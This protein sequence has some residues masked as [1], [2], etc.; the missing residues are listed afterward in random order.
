MNHEDFLRSPICFRQAPEGFSSGGGSLWNNPI[1]RRSFLK[2]TGGATVA[3]FIAWHSVSQISRA[4]TGA[5]AGSSGQHICR[6]FWKG[7][8][9][10]WVDFGQSTLLTQILSDLQRDLTEV[11]KSLEDMEK[12]KQALQTA[13]ANEIPLTGKINDIWNLIKDATGSELSSLASQVKN[14]LSDWVDQKV[15]P[16]ITTFVN[17]LKAS[18]FP[19][20]Y[21]LFNGAASQFNTTL[22]GP[23]VASEATIVDYSTTLDADIDGIGVKLSLKRNLSINMDK[24]PVPGFDAPGGATTKTVACCKNVP[25]SAVVSDRILGVSSVE[26]EVTILVFNATMKGDGE[27]QLGDAVVTAKH[28]AQQSPPAKPTTPPSP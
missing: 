25:Q 3:T 6:A 11:K 23:A 9:W 24:V 5:A 15:W 12:L 27:D 10:V 13:I 21:Y 7:Y 28:K 18:M 14:L 8:E 26:I 19:K 1:T 22:S 20:D 4:D 17:S 2:R 16:H